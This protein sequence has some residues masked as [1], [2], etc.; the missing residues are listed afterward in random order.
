MNKSQGRGKFSNIRLKDSTDT[1]SL[2]STGSLFHRW[3]APIMIIIIIIIVP[4][5]P[6]Y[7]LKDGYGH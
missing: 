4:S 1:A 6:I 2:R 3:G 5:I 7:G